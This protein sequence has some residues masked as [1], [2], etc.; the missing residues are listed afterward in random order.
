MSGKTVTGDAA[1]PVIKKAITSTHYAVSRLDLIDSTGAVVKTF[2]NAVAGSVTVDATNAIRRSFSFTLANDIN[3]DDLLVPGVSEVQAWRGVRLYDPKSYHR[4]IAINQSALAYWRLGEKPGTATAKDYTGHGYDGQY[5]AG[6]ALG[7]PGAIANDTD[8]AAGVGSSATGIA[9]VPTFCAGKLDGKNESVSFWVLTPESVTH[10]TFFKADGTGTANGYGVG[11]GS[12]S[13]D[14]NGWDLLVLFEALRWINLGYT[15]APNTWYHIV[16]VLDENGYPTVY[17][18]GTKVYS[19]TTGAPQPANGDFW[20][21]GYG[22]GRELGAGV[23]DEMAVFGYELAPADVLEQYQL[24][25]GNY[26]T[27]TDYL[28]SLG[29]FGISEDTLSRTQQNNAFTTYDRSRK[30][31][32]SALTD[33]F[34]IPAGTDYGTGIKNLITSRVPGIVFNFTDTSTLGVTP[35]LL[36]QPQDDPWQKSQEMAASIGM[37]LCFDEYGAC[38]LKPVPNALTDP[39]VATYKDGDSA[40]TMTDLSR[41]RSDVD[42]YNHVIVTGQSNGTDPPVTAEAIDDDPTSTTYIGSPPGSSDFGDIP[43]WVN[44]NYITTQAQAQTLA[45][46]TLRLVTGTVEQLSLSAVVDPTLDADQIIKVVSTDGRVNDTYVVESL[47]IPLDVN[48]AL[49]ATTRKKNVK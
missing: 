46:S 14:A 25:V 1:I 17:V 20:I 45:D 26:P 38:R 12:G 33:Y 42:V 10:G 47:T 21:G 48:T 41:I 37:V 8:T 35:L 9:M 29:I 7:S 28:V 31:S 34:A 6:V 49:S 3:V 43:T 30:V 18:N 39:T 2:D 22:S 13:F 36:F 40:N 27:Y 4:A 44:S 19:D 15:L 16:L 11:I 24:G 5:Q 32:R 23:I